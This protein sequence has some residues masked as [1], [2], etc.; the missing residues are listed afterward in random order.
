MC[1][2]FKVTMILSLIKVASYIQALY[3][4]VLFRQITMNLSF[5]CLFFMVKREHNAVP[6]F[7]KMFSIFQIMF[8]K[9]VILILWEFSMIRSRGFCWQQTFSRCLWQSWACSES[10]SSQC[11][12]T[13]PKQTWCRLVIHISR[14]YYLFLKYIADVRVTWRF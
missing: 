14:H 5:V 9:D 6:K 7:F 4:H 13:H 12:L 11:Y 8:I 2:F 1:W 10:W 3:M